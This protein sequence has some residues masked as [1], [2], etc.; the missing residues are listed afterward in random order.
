M[1]FWV[2]FPLQNL[3]KILMGGGKFPHSFPTRCFLYSKY[4][5]KSLSE[6]TGTDRQQRQTDIAHTHQREQAA[7][8]KQRTEGKYTKKGRIQI[9]P[10]SCSKLFQEEDLFL[11]L[12]A[13]SMKKKVGI[14]VEP[15][16]I[17]PCTLNSP[18][19]GYNI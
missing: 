6:T 10:H 2:S 9:W 4:R 12:N 13:G 19:I 15:T 11:F 18:C 7:N 8:H 1:P 3:L 17:I 16:H 14:F 5:A